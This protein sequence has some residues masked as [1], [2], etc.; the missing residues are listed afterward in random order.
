MTINTDTVIKTALES[1]GFSS[2]TGFTSEWNT[3]DNTAGLTISSAVHRDGYAIDHVYITLV[4]DE[5]GALST[6]AE[7]WH[8]TVSGLTIAN[9]GLSNITAAQVSILE[10]SYDKIVALEDTELA[11]AG[12][13]L[14]SQ[15][16]SS[17][18]QA[19]QI[20]SILEQA[21]YSNITGLHVNW[22]TS[23]NTAVVSVNS[24]MQNTLNFSDLNFVYSVD[25]TG[26]LDYYTATVHVPNVGSVSKGLSDLSTTEKSLF[27]SFYDQIEVIEQQ[28]ISI[29]AVAVD[30]IIDSV[31]DDSPVIITGTTSGIS[32][33]QGVTVSF[34]GNSYSTAVTDN[35]WSVT[36][37]VAQAQ[38]L[39]G[40]L[41]RIT[42]EVSDAQG[43]AT[44]EVIRSVDHRA[45][46]APTGITLDKASFAEN[47][48]GAIV[49]S[50]SVTDPDL[51]DSHSLT[52]S[53]TDAALFE[54]DDSDQLKLKSTVS[55]DFETKS[56]YNVTVTATGSDGLSFDQSFTLSVTDVNEAQS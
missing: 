19:T 4:F 35:S 50:L 5:S 31:E 1:L 47:S 42:A 30:D 36:I 56:T 7:S 43:Q 46:H 15:S 17:S 3:G 29:D 48:A 51:A 21:G 25:E 39:A 37:P 12:S 14:Q 8:E 38:A 2:L 10:D 52:L 11:V 16:I 40:G 49:G 33:A 41:A 13:L 55:A 54:V 22:Y 9:V 32:N 27:E 28:S 34:G 23:D 20:Q 24:A 26:V 44:V 18:Y 6:Y 53:G 45:N